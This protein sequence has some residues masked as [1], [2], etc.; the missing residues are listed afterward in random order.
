LPTAPVDLAV[1]GFLLARCAGED[2]YFTVLGDLF[3]TQETLFA[4]ANQAE[5]I[6]YYEGIAAA[7]GVDPDAM[8]LCFAD[9][10]GIDQINA[11]IE[12]SNAHG[13]PGT[14]AFVIN[15][16][17]TPSAQLQDEAGW[18]AALQAALDEAE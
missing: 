8:D 16:V 10:A 14:P 5:L 7:N 6:A 4:S 17:L 18:D 2:Q 13:V 9:Q 15:G 11:A 3:E 12:A 1:A